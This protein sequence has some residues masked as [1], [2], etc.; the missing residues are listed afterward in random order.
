LADGPL[1][2]VLPARPT[3]REEAWRFTPVERLA[4]LYD[5]TLTAAAVD[6]AVVA[7]APVRAEQE[8]IVVPAEALVHDPVLVTVTGQD[9]LAG[10]GRLVLDVGHLAQ[11]TVVLRFTGVASYASDVEVRVGDGAALTLVTVHDW[12]AG[13]LHLDQQQ[14]TLGRDARLRATTVTVGGGLVR[15][16]QGVHYSGPGGDAQVAGLM[17]AGADQHL[18][19]RLRVDHSAPHCRSRVTTKAVLAGK[20]A[21]TVWVGDVLI[22]AQ[23]VGTDTYESNRNLV[24]VDEARAD[25]VPNLEILTGEVVGAGHASATGR[26]DDEQLFYLSSRGIDP[27]TARRLVVR[28]FLAEVLDPLAVLPGLATL[29]HELSGRTLAVTEGESP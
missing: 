14:V 2:S 26:F 28:G 12:A 21:H 20:G 10:A 1:G 25:S 23:A 24:L 17:A 8:R 22:A 18:E 5:A 9:A 19:H 3:G 29:H 15:H 13:A 7:P 6:V 4:V 16:S 11:V 27:L